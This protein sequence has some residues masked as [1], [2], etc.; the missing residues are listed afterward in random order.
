MSGHRQGRWRTASA[1]IS[2]RIALIASLVVALLV[3][4]GLGAGPAAADPT[5]V[6]SGRVTQAGVPVAGVWVEAFGG[7]TSG[8]DITDAEGRYSMTGLAT[9]T[10]RVRFKDQEQLL[11]FP[12]EYYQHAPFA[13][14]AQPVSVTDGAVTDGIDTDLPAGGVISGRVTGAGGVALE[15]ICVGAVDYFRLR[16][17]RRTT[18]GADGRYRIPGL[19]EENYLVAFFDCERNELAGEYYDD[20]RSDLYAEVLSL[21]QGEEIS[22]IDAELARYATVAGRVTAPGRENLAC[23]V[24]AYDRDG[25]RLAELTFTQPDGSYLLERVYPGEVRVQF[26]C[27][28]SGPV[29]T[30]WY[31]DRQSSFSATPVAAAAGAAVTGIDAVVGAPA[32]IAGRAT[33]ASGQP[34]A[35]VCVTTHQGGPG[36]REQATTLA[37]GTYRIDGLTQG[38][39]TVRFADCTGERRLGAVWFGGGGDPASAVPVTATAGQVRADVDA[40]LSVDDAAPD[41]VVTGGPAEG[42]VVAGAP[43]YSFATAA[44]ETDATFQC[45][46][47]GGSWFTCAE[48]FSYVSVRG[49]LNTF[50]VRATDQSGNTDPTPA[51]RTFV[52]DE[53]PPETRITAGPAEGAVARSSVTFAFDGQPAFDTARLECRLDAGAWSTCTSPRTL[54]NLTD[55]SHTFAV[56]AVDAYDQADPTPATRGFVV[57]STRCAT[58]RRDLTSAQAALGTATQRQSAAQKAL[59]KAATAVRRA[60]VAVRAAPRAR[61]PAAQRK[62][63]AALTRQRSASRAVSSA[64]AGVSAARSAVATAQRSVDQSC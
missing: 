55:G 46:L 43:T 23:L 5:G 31:S 54:T 60:R 18:T 24:G 20:Q 3:T 63:K 51:R 61:K 12:T 62:L 29:A 28:A 35:D 59:L 4:S 25:Y 44:P 14:Q 15:G 58:A 33:D 11:G 57:D 10:Y 26:D 39:F 30:E 45:R 8:F 50:E 19:V 34:L 38:Q 40:V 22:G 64:R 47:D 42:A 6:I 41:T 48:E 53:G 16:R 7:A 13:E 2:A 36:Q 52:F 49:G 17:E 56:R 21:P 1:A 37:D 27:D 9:G 32:S